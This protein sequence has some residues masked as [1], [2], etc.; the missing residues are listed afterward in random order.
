MVAA[1]TEAAR[2]VGGAHQAMTLVKLERP[3]ERARTAVSLSERYTTFQKEA[4]PPIAGKLCALVCARNRPLR[5]T[6]RELS[7]HPEWLDNGGQRPPPRGYLAVP[8]TAAD[9]QN[10]G[11]IQL[12]DWHDGEF[13]DD[14]E[15][16]LVQLAQLASIAIQNRV[17]A[18]E[19]E[20][21][22]LK[23]EFLAML[24]HELRS[25]STRS[26]AGRTSC[27]PSG[28]M[29]SGCPRA[30]RGDRAQRGRADAAHRGS[31]RRLADHDA[32]S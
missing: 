31:P 8:L 9:G 4:P 32:A 14:D 21:N 16:V 15:T 23:D 1:I 25:R 28:S 18:E 6:Q 30:P 24:S 10:I 29:S 7:L 2:D 27:A 13:S 12:L 19:R 26:S 22:R 11:S 17:H 3:G 20:A 5:L